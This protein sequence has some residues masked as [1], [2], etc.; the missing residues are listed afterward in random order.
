MGIATGLAWGQ[1]TAPPALP[2]QTS[3]DGVPTFSLTTRLV[4]LDV[5]VT[6]KAGQ[7]VRG[8]G[9]EDFTI[10]EDGA[11][12]SVRSFEGLEKHALPPEVKI[13]STADLAKAPDAPV[14]ILVLD[15]LNTAFGDMSFARASLTSYLNHQPAVLTQPTT[16][17]VVN[18]SKFQVLQD[19]TLD[20]EK[21]LAV[22][23]KHFPEYPWRLMRSGKGGPGAAER[24]AMSLGSLEQVAQAS[25]G[26]PGRKN[27]IWVG[28]GF[29]AINT[30][31]ST[32]REAAVLLQAMQ[33]AFDI[34]RDA[35]ITMSSIDPTIASSGTTLIETPDDLDS[36]E[37][38]NGTDPLAG[39]MNF[40]LLAPATGGRVYNSRN[41]V[42]A[43]IG[44]T[45]RD[46]SNYY[47]LTYKPGN[48]SDAA[49]PYRRIQIKMNRPGLK[50]TTRN[51]YY[52]QPSAPA[53]ENAEA[54]DQQ[55][56]KLA[57]DLGSA[58]NSNIS[59][60]GLSL[61]AHRL[62]SNGEFAVTVDAKDLQA[63]FKDSGDSEAEVTL[64]I[65]SFNDRRM[66]A[67]QIAEMKARILPSTATRQTAE[68]HLKTSIPSDTTRV[69]VVM[70]D[71]NNGKIGTA[72]LSP[73]EFKG[74]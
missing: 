28:R 52:I 1:N 35:R 65:A 9:K 74:K 12:Q 17:L 5:V 13:E 48:G 41:D 66:L 42:D 2:S 10:L 8:L 25:S 49:Q 68:F 30:K 4:V 23:R 45:I 33:H 18:N 70:R 37:N 71:A 51:G 64:I 40:E 44:T 11:A 55:R 46:G 26:H 7:I 57:F 47:T 61:T 67:H 62:P 34:L 38:D 22:L 58:A 59:Y 54:L 21:L 43:M 53:V 29:P 3:Y 39:D 36:A 31:E 20:R 50:A 32:D 16:L 19:Y 24:L 56:K 14:S 69:R 60:T 73:E 63:I 6:D 15:E 72:D 27:L